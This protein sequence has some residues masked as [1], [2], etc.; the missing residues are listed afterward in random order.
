MKVVGKYLNSF[1]AN[2]AKGMLESAGIKAAVMNE[3]LPIISG[4]TNDDLLSITLVVNDE[5]YQEAVR[6][7]EASSNAE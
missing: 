3:Y 7:L 1:S 2:V 5:D 4:I 6:L